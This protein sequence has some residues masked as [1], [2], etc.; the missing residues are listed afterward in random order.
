MPWLHVLWTVF[1]PE[2]KLIVQSYWMW[3]ICTQKINEEGFEKQWVIETL[4]RG[5][6]REIIAAGRVRMVIFLV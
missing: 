4:Q 2:L 3:R 1:Q 5:Y 6:R